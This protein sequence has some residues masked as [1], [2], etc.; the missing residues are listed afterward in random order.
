MAGTS[1]SDRRE[2]VVALMLILRVVC[3]T[4]R[5]VKRSLVMDDHVVARVGRGT[6]DEWVGSIAPNVAKH[7]GPF[8][9]GPPWRGG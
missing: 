1:Q 5:R 6:A 9:R 2:S 4:R 8:G 7:K 3:W